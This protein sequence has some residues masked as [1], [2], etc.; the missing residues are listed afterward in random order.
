MV[1]PRED[2][3]QPTP[4]G[5]HEAR[6]RELTN[7]IAER[8]RRVCGDMPP[9]EFAALARSIAGVRMK[10]DEITHERPISVEPN[11]ALRP[12]GPLPPRKQ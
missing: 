7:D 8:L 1:P 3:P 10:Y 11:Y 4:V 2:E 9:D 5:G 12:P 6:L